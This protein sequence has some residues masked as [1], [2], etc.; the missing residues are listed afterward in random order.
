MP[1][2]TKIKIKIMGVVFFFAITIFYGFIFNFYENLMD[3][4][5]TFLIELLKLI[6]N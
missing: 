2:F 1:H 3:F 5:V 4:A 6:I